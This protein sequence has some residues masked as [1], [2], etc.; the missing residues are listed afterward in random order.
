[1]IVD[2]SLIKS[3]NRK[4]YNLY[5]VGEGVYKVGRGRKTSETFAYATTPDGTEITIDA[6]K[7]FEKYGMQE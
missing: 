2:Q 6:V 3:I 4:Q 5:A 1:M 7:Y